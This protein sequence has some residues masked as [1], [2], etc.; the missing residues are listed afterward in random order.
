MFYS[1]V[2]APGKPAVYVPPPSEHM[3][4]LSQAALPHDA[5]VGTRVSL[6]VR[7]GDE[8]PA[9]L[10]TLCAGRQ[11]TIPLDQFL[12]GYAE[13][14]VAGNATVHLSGYFAPAFE[15]D[16]EEGGDDDDEDADGDYELPGGH[17]LGMMIPGDS[18]SD[19]DEDEDGSGESDDEGED[20]EDDGFGFG[21]TPAGRGKEPSAVVTEIEDGPPNGAKA[22]KGLPARLAAASGGVGKAG[23]ALEESSDDEKG[24]SDDDDNSGDDEGE[25]S[26][27]EAAAKPG[28]KR[29]A[30][31]ATA[32]PDGKKQ[33]LGHKQ[34]QAKTP[35]QQQAKTPRQQ[36][37]KT[38][39]QQPAKTPQQQ[40][41]KT[42]QQQPAKTPPQ[43]QQAKT[44]LSA[45][46]LGKPRVFENG[47]EIHDLKMGQPDG[48]LAR[49]GK[50]V[51]MRYVGRLKKN[52]KVFDSN[53]KG[54]PF[55]FRLG[56]GEVIKGWD[57]GVEGMRVGDKRKLVIPPQM[58][59]GS[60]KIPGI[61]PNST[62]EFEVELVDVK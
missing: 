6:L 60:Q 35:P 52:G 5:P 11:D 4:H 50:K 58:A 45:R 30:A 1:G 39:P 2:V 56:V 36:Q 29:K 43:Q 28:D 59:Y 26:E 19:L 61:P 31:A 3:L 10:C 9:V 16:D 49:A 48:R 41:A 54:K 27:E 62:L 51:S 40:E 17:P 46:G 14:T 34:Q 38:P 20:D 37:A 42:P 33:A 23:R 55:A 21:A 13:F 18:D 25:E 57:R 22:L 47:F 44:P 12:S 8:P 15:E 53:T 7:L 32:A 24:E